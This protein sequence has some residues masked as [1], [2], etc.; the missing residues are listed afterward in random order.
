MRDS[1]R[2]GRR[3]PSVADAG[4]YAIGAPG[5]EEGVVR[6]P[7]GGGRCCSGCLSFG[8]RVSNTLGPLEPVYR[9]ERGQQSGCLNSEASTGPSLAMTPL[10]CITVCLFCG[11]GLSRLG[12]LRRMQQKLLR[13]TPNSRADAAPPLVSAPHISPCRCSR[14]LG[15]RRAIS[16]F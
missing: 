16:C 7:R 1:R 2:A 13:F 4:G 3:V 9:A 15:V 6:L 10:V 11:A 14:T 5:R 12:R 8:P